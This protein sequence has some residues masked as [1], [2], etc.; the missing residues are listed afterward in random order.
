MNILFY[1]GFFIAGFKTKQNQT[2]TTTTKTHHDPNQL[3][4]ERVY[5]SLKLSGH[6]PSLRKDREGVCR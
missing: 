6:V 4:E 3:G 2:K 5:I 1:L